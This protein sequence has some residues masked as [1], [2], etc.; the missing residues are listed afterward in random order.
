MAKKKTGK[1][2][3]Q[4]ATLRNVRVSRAKEKT[5]E[6]R[7]RDLESKVILMA[8]LMVDLE[9]TLSELTTTAERRTKR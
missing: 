5:L 4:D 8:E 9:A 7:V 1:K 6:I 2:N 3:A